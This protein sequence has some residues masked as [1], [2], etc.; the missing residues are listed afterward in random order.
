MHCEALMVVLH[1]S[2]LPQEA[3]CWGEWKVAHDAQTLAKLVRLSR[4]LKLAKLCAF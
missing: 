2:E 1:H 4:V 3:E